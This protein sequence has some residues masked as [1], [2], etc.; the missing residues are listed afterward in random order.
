MKKLWNYLPLHFCICVIVGIYVQYNFKIWDYQFFKLGLLIAVILLFL[1]LVN[2][3]L[4]RTLITLFLFFVLGVSSVFIQNTSNYKNYYQNYFTDNCNVILKVD[5]ILKSDIY[6]Y[7]FEAK[8]YQVDSIKTRGKILLN[9]KKDSTDLTLDVNDF[10]FLK[11]S[12]DDLKPP[13]NPYQFDY[14]E[15]LRKRGILQQIFTDKYR[16]KV[17]KNENFSLFSF[18]DSFRKTTLTSLKKNNFSKD[19]LGVI[20]ALL[21]GLRKEVSKELITDYSRAGAIHILAISGLHVGIILLILNWL[22][23]P[24]EYFRKGKLLKTIIIVF[25]L[26]VFAFVAGLSASVVRSV[27]MFTFLA[28]GLFFQRKNIIEFSLLSSCFF[29]LIFNPMFLFDVGFQLSYLAVFSIVSIQPKLSNLWK[30]KHNILTF[31]WNLFTVSIAAQ[32]GILPLSIFYFHQFPGLFLLSNLIIIPF[33]G[34]ILFGGILVIFLASLNI[35]QKLLA[36]FYGFVISTMNNFV[37]WISNQ[38]AFLFQ[39]ISISFFKMICM[40]LLIFS[41]MIIFVRFSAKKLI[42]LLSCIILLQVNSVFENYQ[43]NHSKEFILFHKSRNSI[44]GSR[45]GEN[46]SIHHNLE[47]SKV[48]EFSFLKSFRNNNN[49]KL[50]HVSINNNI[51]QLDKHRFL[52]VDS[53]GVYNLKGL[54]NSNVILQYSPKIN[55]E[56]LIST[57]KPT[58]IIAD[59]SNYK[60]YVANWAKTSSNNNIPFHYTGEKGAFILRE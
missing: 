5:K 3:C 33:L 21:L 48:E 43:I 29:L 52:V 4:F 2:H 26:W 19:E 20:S 24:I 56:R 39:D 17:V 8:V 59:G 51:F 38:E 16:Y 11:P 6:N 31:F 10:I 30:P 50:R 14:R 12:F 22:L 47:N 36:E 41:L 54:E 53:L 49:L 37:V 27:T 23:K 58:I 40:Y 28:C 42:F 32:I 45:I 35:L 1:L 55:L 46:L 34:F 13:L 60:S 7:K 9:I 57:L 18:A 15:Y 44:V 25:M